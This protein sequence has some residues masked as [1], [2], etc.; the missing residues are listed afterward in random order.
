[1]KKIS[2]FIVKYSKI[3]LVLFAALIV[4]SILSINKVNIE[5]SVTSYLPIETDTKKALDIMDDEFVTYG[6]ST[7]LI[8]NIPYEDAYKL[9][10]EIVDIEGVKELK[11]ENTEDYYKES[12]ALFSIT[13]T[14][15]DEDQTS[16]NAYNEVIEKVKGYD[17]LVAARLVDN[18]ADQLQSDINKILIYVII[19]IIIV[20]L[21]TS[22]S[23]AEVLVF[24]IVF[25]VA[26]LL[27]MGTN[28]WFGTIS[29][30]SNSVCVILQLAL[31]IDYAIIL[32]HR[33]AEEKM[34]A[35]N[36]EDA[37]IEALAKAISEI[38]E[39]VTSYP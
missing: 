7:I 24:L 37:M 17:A 12:T 15:D 13:Y 35:N 16:I 20:L 29:F 38:S 34:H 23:V 26:A 22:N 3:I 5:Y 11:F 21:F 6:T 4:Y 30:I 31:A 28:Y 19:I 10:E 1:M 33:F 8:R 27:N 2:S 9:T 39:E 36:S 14:G 25:G 18:Y 32:S